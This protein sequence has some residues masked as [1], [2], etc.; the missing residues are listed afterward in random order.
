MPLVTGNASSKLGFATTSAPDWNASMNIWTRISAGN[1]AKAP[2]Q[3]VLWEESDSL[4]KQVV[5]S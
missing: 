5:M 3:L 4:S 2:W 1:R